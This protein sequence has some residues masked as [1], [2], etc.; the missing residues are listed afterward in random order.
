VK[1]QKRLL[2]PHRKRELPSGFSWV[3]HRLVRDSHIE[4]CGP[5][6]LALYLFLVTVGDAEGLSYYGDAAIA[7][8]LHLSDVEL[9]D[10]RKDLRRAG[11]IAW[12]RPL[13]QVLGLDPAVPATRDIRATP[14]PDAGRG[15]TTQSIGEILRQ[16]A[17]E[18]GIQ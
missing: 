4:K 6:A 16:A 13:Y 12:E 15:G 8:R 3:D 7:R 2:C 17:G 18:G 14:V 1:E 5:P 9:A 10:A 11:L